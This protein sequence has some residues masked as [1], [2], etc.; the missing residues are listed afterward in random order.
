MLKPGP[1]PRT[2][3]PF[4]F[5]EVAARKNG[6]PRE[7]LCLHGTKCTG[8]LT[9]GCCRACANLYSVRTHQRG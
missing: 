3:C 4:C 5:R 9:V 7:H 2:Q 6:V 1:L 8:A